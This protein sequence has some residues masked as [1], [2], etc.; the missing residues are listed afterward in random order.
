MIH[1]VPFVDPGKIYLKLKNELD[2]AYFEIMTKGDLVDRSQLRSFEEY[3]ARFVGTK[4]AVGLNSGY[5]ALHLSLRAAGIG[6]RDEVIVPAHTFV[7]TCSAVV[8]TGAT[9][10]LADVGK[11]FNIDTEK[12]EELITEKTNLS[13][14]Q[15][16]MNISMACND[17]STHQEWTE[18]YKRLTYW[19]MEIDK[20][21]NKSMHDVLETQKTEA[22]ASFAKF[23]KNKNFGIYS[24]SI[25]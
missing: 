15:D 14:R 6:I 22:N 13:Y 25:S 8:N 21:E 17:A 12:I 16:F 24:I 19:E 3:L 10:V 11:D 4:Y 5:D 20:T 2:Q 23:I 7:A 18:I 9:P 1:K